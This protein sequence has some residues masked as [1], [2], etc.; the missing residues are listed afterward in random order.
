MAPVMASLTSVEEAQE[1]TLPLVRPL[2]AAL[3]A[4]SAGDTVEVILR[5]MP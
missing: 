4:C 2:A 5:E 1:I 3:P